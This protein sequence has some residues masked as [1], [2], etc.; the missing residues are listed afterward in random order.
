MAPTIRPLA[1]TELP[2]ARALLAIACRFDRADLVAD[3]KL[4]GDA[5][6]GPA[7]PWAA[8]D[9]CNDAALLGIAVTS[10]R[11]VRL[12]AVAPDARGRGVGSALLAHAEAALRGAGVTTARVVGQPGNF[13]APGVD[14]RDADT[15]AWLERR[16]WIAS[17]HRNVNLLVDTAID[18]ARAEAARA[19]IAAAGYTVRRGTATDAAIVAP[20]AGA[21]FGGS[22]P[23]EIA[24]AAEPPSTLFVAHHGD[25]LAGF[26][27]HDGNNR[28]LGW[29]GPAGT[30]PAHRGRG[31]G[32]VLLH[33]CLEDI[34]ADHAVCEVAWIGPRTFYERAC[35]VAGERRFV[36]LSKEL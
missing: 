19:R 12:L 17:A 26:A 16:D 15:V 4:F 29:F 35:R 22:W 18:A 36:P 24:R 10:G 14:E 7:A 23:F 20:A 6:D 30:W 5:P 27:V 31:L 3:E 25:Q 2:A 11:H 13:L 34:A 1:R 33:A 8:C 32:E 9:P 21:G 28:G